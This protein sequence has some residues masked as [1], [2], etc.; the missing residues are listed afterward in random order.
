MTDIKKETNE[1]RDTKEFIFRIGTKQDLIEFSITNSSEI[2]DNIDEIL[3]Y[4]DILEKV[5]KIS[6]LR[7]KF[8]EVFEA[9]PERVYF[10]FDEKRIKVWEKIGIMLFSRYPFPTNRDYI[11]KYGITNSNLI[12]YL[13]RHEDIFLKFD[14]NRIT[15]SKKG[16]N[17]ILDKLNE[18]MPEE[19]EKDNTANEEENE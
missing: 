7:T 8:S 10:Y 2:E 12:T 17:H 15:L 16:F 1:E 3:Y 11:Y 18:L 5:S 14:D 6:S 13:D 4:K 9:T 19:A